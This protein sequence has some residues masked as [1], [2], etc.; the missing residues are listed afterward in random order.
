M[1]SEFPPP[2]LF[3]RREAALA[4]LEALARKLWLGAT[5]NSQGRLGTR[6]DALVACRKALVTG[7]LPVGDA[8]AW[9]DASL[10][11]PLAEVMAELGLP[12]FCK[13]KAELTDQVVGSLLWH[14]DRIVDFQDRAP[15]NRRRS[16][17]CSM[18]SAPTGA[19]VA[20]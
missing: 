5:I 11:G 8:L 15:R 1:I 20:A 18:N 10:G 6:L 12:A 13:D 9:P 19:S 3:E 16:R 14:L 2:L 7:G 17:A 4:S